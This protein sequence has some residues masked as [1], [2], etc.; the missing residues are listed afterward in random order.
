MT[1]LWWPGQPRSQPQPLS[2]P[3]TCSYCFRQGTTLFYKNKSLPTCQR[4]VCPGGRGSSCASRRRH[5]GL[6]LGGSTPWRTSSSLLS[7]S[8][9]L[10]LGVSTH[11]HCYGDDDGLPAHS[12]ITVHDIMICSD[13]F[14]LAQEDWTNDG[15]WTHVKE[16]NIGELRVVG[17]ELNASKWVWIWDL[18]RTVHIFH[19]PA[20]WSWVNSQKQAA[21]KQWRFTRRMEEYLMKIV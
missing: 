17:V 9:S 2:F 7:S 6:W 1:M 12:T 18:V 16:L 8:L 11:H 21:L 13:M 4:D 19:R 20:F 10:L 14:C 3:W 5:I 15:D